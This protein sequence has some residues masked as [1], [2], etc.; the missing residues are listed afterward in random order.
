M[1]RKKIRIKIKWKKGFS[2]NQIFMPNISIKVHCPS[3]R[4]MQCE[5][6]E[7]S[8]WNWNKHRFSTRV[9]L[10]F[11][12]KKI[13]DGKQQ[14]QSRDRSPGFFFSSSQFRLIANVLFCLRRGL[15][16]NGSASGIAS[17]KSWG[18]KFGDKWR[19]SR[20]TDGCAW[21]VFLGLL[22][23]DKGRARD[24]QLLLAPRRTNRSIMVPQGGWDGRMSRQSGGSPVISFVFKGCFLI[25]YRMP[26]NCCW[27][28]RIIKLLTDRKG[29]S[30]G[31]SLITPIP[32]G[33]S[34][35]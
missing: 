10:I 12:K 21:W 1:C 24:D 27:W 30:P 2:F 28:G 18:V 19:S 15:R 31:L 23:N 20:P 11:K 14:R 17:P 34:D 33:L 26:L 29:F 32:S 35:V 16:K 22:R 3:L 9:D 5:S 4:Q 6:S 8:K 13:R 7:K 25:C